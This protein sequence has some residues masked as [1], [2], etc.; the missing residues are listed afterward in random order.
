[1]KTSQIKS[2]KPV[3]KD[4]TVRDFSGGWDILDDEVNLNSRYAVRMY[5]CSVFADGA[6]NVRY[7]TELFANLALYVSSAGAYP[8]NMEYYN[9]ALIVVCSNGDVLRILADGTISRI[10][11]SAIASALPGNPAGW[12]DTEFASFAQFN[13]SLIICN[14]VDKP[15]LVN[16]TFVVDYLQDE[17][18]SSNLNT[19]ICRYVTV[20]GRFLVMAGDPVNPYRV[21]I[22]SQDTSGTWFDDPDPNDATFIDVGT[23]LN[24]ATEIRGIST[25]R[26]K[27]IVAF[28]EGTILGN[29]GIFDE[30]GN[31][32]PNFDETVEQYGSVSHR[33]M[34]NYGEDM[35]MMDLVGIP[36][37]K[38]TVY[39]GTIK[40]DRVSELIDPDIAS[41]IN[42]LSFGTLENRCFALYN[43]RDGQFLF[44]VPNSDSIDTTTQTTAYSLIY[45]PSLKVNSWSRYDGWNFTC[46]CRTSQGEV[47]FGD[48]N[49]KIWLLGSVHNENYTDY[50][51]DSDVNGG[52]GVPITFDWEL[53]WSDIQ[54]RTKSKTSKYLKLD[55]S[56]TGEFTVEMYI[57][58]YRYDQDGLDSP[59]LSMSMIG[60]DAGGFGM[61]YTPYGGGRNTADEKL[62]GWPSKFMWM[63]LRFTGSVTNKLKFSAISLL[64]TQ[65][66]IL[67]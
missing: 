21:H 49:G 54:E 61:G 12:S 20:C 15:L 2:A 56:G 19:P 40:P 22:S 67:R 58:R 46:G 14:G 47:F 44:F 11:D 10:W 4:A 35:L 6:V 26:G 48:V 30:E 41:K 13:G 38:K 52:D 31:H 9:A 29:L 51:N 34:I 18:T 64:Y 37:L 62:Y 3:L 32:T 5:N 60:G 66:N 17:G 24:G 50:L 65:G 1:M 53:P 36:S 43:Q 39:S 59:F 23:Y 28:A 8:I 63:K 25:F 55:T 16:S 45:R 57:D 27:L 7:G 33:S 42:N